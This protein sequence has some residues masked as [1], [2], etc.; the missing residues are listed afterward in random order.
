M[1]SSEVTVNT[2]IKNKGFSL[3]DDLFKTNGWHIVNNE[4]DRITYTKTG[5][6]TE[7][8]DLKVMQNNIQVSIPLKNSRFQYTTSFK[9]YFTATEYIETRFKEFIL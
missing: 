9:D 1:L 4:M 8:F 6:E 2:E 7:F 5:H 3:M